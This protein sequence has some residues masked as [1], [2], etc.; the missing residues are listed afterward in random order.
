MLITVK[1]YL[2]GEALPICVP[3]IKRMLIT[4]S[5]IVLDGTSA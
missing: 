4:E 2:V 3:S 1:F 5:F